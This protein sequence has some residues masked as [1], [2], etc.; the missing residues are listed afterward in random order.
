[1]RRLLFA[2]A[3]VLGLGLLFVRCGGSTVGD[4]DGGAEGGGGGGPD[5]CACVDAQPMCK[6]GDTKKVDCNT[7]TCSGGLWACT[8]LACVDAGPPEGGLPTTDPGSVRCNGATCAAINHFCCDQSGA[9]SCLAKPIP[10]ACAGFTRE[11]DEKAD[12][13]GQNVCCIPPN[14]SIKVA[15]NTRCEANCGNNDPFSYQVCKTSAEC[16]NGMACIGQ[17][18]LGTV[19]YT[20]GGLIPPNRCQ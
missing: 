16:L 15:Y 2:C 6:D 17:P 19:I 4:L 10:G 1:M 9:E 14:A 3:S 20:C 12:C 5:A 11:C 13:I 18:C 8:L 7:C